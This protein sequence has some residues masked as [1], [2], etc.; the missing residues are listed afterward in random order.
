MNNIKDF[1]S[2]PKKT[3]ILG[4]I[5]CSLMLLLNFII[6]FNIFNILT[7]LYVIGLIA[8]F[9]I[10]LIKMYNK[11]VNIKIA[12]YIL[13][14]AYSIQLLL[15]LIFNI[16]HLGFSRY[17]GYINFFRL[18]C[19]FAY[20]I[21][22]LYFFN[23]LLRKKN[24]VNNKFFAVVIII[25]TVIELVSMMR[26]S[27]YGNVEILI[28]YYISYIFIIPYFYNYYKILKGENLMEK[29]E[30]LEAIG[31]KVVKCKECC[32]D[33][34]EEEFN[35]YK[36]YCKNC[37]EN[38]ENIA[39]EKKLSNQEK[40]KIA[41]KFKI[42]ANILRFFGYGMAILWAILHI[43]DYEAG[44]GIFVGIAIAIITWLS[45][46]F[47]EAIAEALQLLEDIKNK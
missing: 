8:Y 19:I 36:G 7:D 43:A 9:I 45:C 10:V 2:S 31:I 21:P 22:I 28:I 25:Y 1:L 46:L 41:S 34:S 12:N 4:L 27:I 14:L 47:W 15:S 16:G 6:N 44:F 26:Y 35:S 32:K 33:I 37:Y 39:D 42:V 17:L 5:V 18:F 11:Q 23:I 3:A 13:I 30:E 29:K 24:F 38:K 20:I 40:N